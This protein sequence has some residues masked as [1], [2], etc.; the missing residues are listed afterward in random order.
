MRKATTF[1]TNVEFRCEENNKT[2]ELKGLLER[3][4][5]L[6]VV[7]TDILEAMVELARGLKEDD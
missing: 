3:V 7:E 4:T 6:S 5:S 2:A 1:A